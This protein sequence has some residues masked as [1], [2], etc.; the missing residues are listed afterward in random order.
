MFDFLYPIVTIYWISLVFVESQVKFQRNMSSPTPGWKSKPSTKPPWSMHLAELLIG[1]LFVPED[2]GDVFFQ[3]IG[4]VSTDYT[5][6]H[7]SENITSNPVQSDLTF[8]IASYD[9]CSLSDFQHT[10]TTHSL[11]KLQCRKLR[12]SILLLKTWIGVPWKASVLKLY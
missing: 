9:I 7:I 10:Q 11:M 6:Q 4:W 12:L 3:I 8:Q 2:G 1:L 5:Q